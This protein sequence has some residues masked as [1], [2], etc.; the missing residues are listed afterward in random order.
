MKHKAHR[1]ER[2]IA[3]TKCRQLVNGSRDDFGFH[4]AKIRVTDRDTN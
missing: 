2:K 3:R 4:L 1:A